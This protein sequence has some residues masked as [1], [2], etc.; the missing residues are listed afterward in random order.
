MPVGYA[1]GNLP[2]IAAD[3]G[4]LVPAG[5]TAALGEALL[6]IAR[7]LLQE[8]DRQVDLDAGRFSLAD[9]DAFSAEYVQTFERK[10][11]SPLVKREVEA[12]LGY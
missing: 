10:N 1:C 8:G 11:V 3:M 12:L 9:F 2:F 7:D 4:R 6:S 5:D